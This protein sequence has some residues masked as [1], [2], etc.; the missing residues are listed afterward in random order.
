MYAP[1]DKFRLGTHAKHQ[2]SMAVVYLDFNLLL[3]HMHR[4]RAVY[5]NETHFGNKVAISL[6]L[7][8]NV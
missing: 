7:L 2:C 5:A 8:D 4:S 6:L 1:I 3:S